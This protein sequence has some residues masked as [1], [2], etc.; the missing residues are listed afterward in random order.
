ML[1]EPTNLYIDHNLY[2]VVAKERLLKAKKYISSFKDIEKYYNVG[3]NPSVCTVPEQ[4][5]IFE[6]KIVHLYSLVMSE[7]LDWHI[8]EMRGDYWSRAKYCCILE[9]KGILE[10]KHN[11]SD[12]IESFEFDEN[13]NRYQWIKFAHTNVHRF[14]TTGAHMAVANTLPPNKLSMFGKE[15]YYS[16]DYSVNA[17][18]RTVWEEQKK[19]AIS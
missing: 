11:D 8:D 14:I 19:N 3:D 6:D 2:Y 1:F 5:Q 10:I 4:F 13:F 17:I 12:K 18:N 15:F 9:G 7:I 16:N